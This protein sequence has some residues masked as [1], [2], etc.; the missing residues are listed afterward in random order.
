MRR[1]CCLNNEN[2]FFDLS[3][4]FESEMYAARERSHSLACVHHLFGEGR[5]DLVF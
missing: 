1:C 4:H 5:W 2:V 3:L